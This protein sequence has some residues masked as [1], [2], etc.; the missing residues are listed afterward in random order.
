MRVPKINIKKFSL[1]FFI[2]LS[3]FFR[4]LHQ[5]EQ[6]EKSMLRDDSFGTVPQNVRLKKMVHFLTR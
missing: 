4:G 2:K 3:S 5:I 6:D 1:I